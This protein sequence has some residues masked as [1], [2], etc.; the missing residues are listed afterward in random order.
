MLQEKPAFVTSGL[1]EGGNL[2]IEHGA[3]ADGQGK[4]HRLS[5]VGIGQHLLGGVRA[6]SVTWIGVAPVAL[7]LGQ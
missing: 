4:L 2:L 7:G 3:G 6:Y 1:D 5:I